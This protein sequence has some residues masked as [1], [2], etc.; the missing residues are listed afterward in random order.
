MKESAQVTKLVCGNG[1]ASNRQCLNGAECLMVVET[2]GLEPLP[3]C[4]V[5]PVREEQP[6][7]CELPRFGKPHSSSHD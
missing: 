3:T 6:H 4:P 7:E 1:Y 2:D 5:W